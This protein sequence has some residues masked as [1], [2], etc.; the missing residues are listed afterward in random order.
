MTNPSAGL[1]LI[2]SSLV[3]GYGY[4]DHAETEIRSLLGNTKR[5]LFFPY[6]LKKMDAYM[7]RTKKQKLNFLSHKYQK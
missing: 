2:S 1:L 5:V 7:L 4:L 3:Y 6:A